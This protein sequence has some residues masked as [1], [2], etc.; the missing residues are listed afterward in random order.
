MKLAPLHRFVGPFAAAL[1]QPSFMLAMVAWLSVLVA[2]F[3]APT[4]EGVNIDA[5]VYVDAFQRMLDGQAAYLVPD[6]IATAMSDGVPIYFFPPPFAAVAGGLV[7]VMPG[8][9]TLWFLGSFVVDALAFLVLRRST[10]TIPEY[11]AIV[12]R[13][14]LAFLLPLVGWFL[15]VPTTRQILTGNQSSLIL[16]GTVLLAI[17][18]IGRRPWQVGLGLGMS[19]LLKLSPILFLGPLAVGRRWRDIGLTLLVC[20][21]GFFVSVGIA[22]VQ[23]WLDFASAL[24]S[25]SSRIAGQ[26]YNM[27][28]LEKILPAVPDIAWIGILAVAMLP[29]GRLEPRR[30]IIV[31]IALFLLLWPVQWIHYGVIALPA[32]VLL[33]ADRRTWLTTAA[34]YIL[35]QVVWPP[36]WLAATAL[37][38]LAALR[39]DLTGRAQ[40][41]LW[42]WLSHVATCSPA[43]DAT[44]AER[45]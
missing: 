14:V 1:I 45:G 13:P 28:P 4:P 24:A 2:F 5:F 3:F 10:P 16:L 18:V 27:A 30:M 11:R 31:S 23:P 17:G 12:R 21:V 39:P 40:T 7:V 42:T 20:A 32:L 33:I 25:Q 22:G 43:S 36:A 29:A 44:R 19:I 37:L 9:G 38:L 8:G 15:F 6:P 35:L 34:V 41:A 26:G